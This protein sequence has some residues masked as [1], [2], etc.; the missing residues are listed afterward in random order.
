MRARASAVRWPGLVACL[1]L[2]V[3]LGPVAAPVRA[4]AAAP[5]KIGTTE[6]VGLLADTYGE[7]PLSVTGGTPPYRWA[8]RTSGPEWNGLT[9]GSDGVLRGSPI[10]QSESTLLVR[11]FDATGAHADAN[12]RLSTVYPPRIDTSELAGAYRGMP[13]IARLEALSGLPPYAWS[14]ASGTIPPGLQLRDLQ[15]GD[16]GPGNGRISGT[17]TAAGSWTFTLAVTDSLGR[18]A[19]RELTLTVREPRVPDAP[20]EAPWEGAVNS[21]RVYRPAYD[22][23]APLTGG[24]VTP[25][26]NGVAL[27]PIFDPDLADGELDLLD[28]LPRG[29]YTFTSAWVNQVGTGPASPM[30]AP[31]EVYAIPSAPTDLRVALGDRSATVTWKRGQDGGERIAGYAVEVLQSG[32]SVRWASVPG[33]ARTATITGLSVGSTYQFAVTAFSETYGGTSARSAPFVVVAAAGKPTAVAASPGDRSSVLRWTAPTRPEDAAPITG[34]QV[35]PYVDGVAQPPVA[36]AGTDPTATVPGLVNGTTYTFTVAAVNAA[37]PGAPSDPSNAVVASATPIA[38]SPPTAGAVEPVAGGARVSWTAPLSTGGAA[39]TGYRVTPYAGTTALAPRTFS[40][41]A[42]T[43]TVTGLVD[44]TAY[45]FRIAAVNAAGTGEA[46]SATTAVVAGAPGAPTEVVARPGATTVLVSWTPPEA[47]GAPI[48]SY[49]IT[50]LRGT[51][52]PEQSIVVSGSATSARISVQNPG[53]SYRVRVAAVNSRGTSADSAPSNTVDVGGATAPASVHVVPR[54][55]TALVSWPG[56]GPEDGP[57]NT[58]AVIAEADDAAGVRDVLVVANA[59]ATSATVRDLVPGVPYRI[60]IIAFNDRSGGDKVVSEPFVV[61]MPDAPL[62]VRAVPGNGTA[63]VTATAPVADAAAVTSYRVTPLVNGVARPTQTFSGPS[64]SWKVTGL[65]NGTVHTFRVVAVNATGTSTPATT[66]A[67][68]I[69]VPLPPSTV[70]AKAGRGQATVTFSS[71]DGNGARIVRYVVTPYLDG[72]A[73]PARAFDATTR[74]RTI[75]GLRSGRSYTFTVQATNS[76]GTSVA[77]KP[78]AAIRPS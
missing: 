34:W 55:T 2:A 63:T 8:Q 47:N 69:G 28:R 9:L 36:V 64:R 74:T 46:S 6:I 35:T 4:D 44:G 27:E 76:R 51:T 15:D 21:L 25:Y 24:V 61:G 31:I 38:P 65:A 54:G 70:T 49:V 30:S 72:V 71:G 19:T 26:R 58:Y 45:T 7:T 68:R 66:V 14:V 1:L 77:S 32:V 50:P 40:S 53:Y 5:L 78:S 57:P 10:W 75:T 56:P 67:I 41:T 59:P 18:T 52:V 20:P 39:I 60:S 12:V 16:V 11:V 13:Y 29:T 17:P 23:G 42:T 22:G 48:T 3:A 62:G 33:E 73:Q 43:Q 37:G